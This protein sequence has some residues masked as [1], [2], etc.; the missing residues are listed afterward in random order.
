MT[1]DNC[2]ICGKRKKRIWHGGQHIC[3]DHKCVSKAWDSYQK[4]IAK[5]NAPFSCRGGK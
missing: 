3:D 5:H 1:S 2:P 4:N